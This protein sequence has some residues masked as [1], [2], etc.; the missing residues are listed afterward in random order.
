MYDFW[1]FLHVLSAITWVGAATLALF[2]SLRLSAQRDNPVAA[3]A[4]GLLEKTAVPLF[5]AAS[6]GTLI[7]GLILAFGWI[8]FDP[9]WIK[10]GLAGVLVSI[11]VGFGYFKPHGEKLGAAMEAN[12]PGD[13]KVQVMVRQAQIVSLVE[14]VIFAVVVWAMVTKP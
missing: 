1:Q 12:G 9:L 10:I 14:L 11:V 2:L 3:P 7:T 4:S 5:M 13:P 8:G 6:L